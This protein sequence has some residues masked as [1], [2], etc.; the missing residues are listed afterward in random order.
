MKTPAASER[1]NGNDL[2]HLV[3]I[4]SLIE[5]VYVLS[6]VLQQDLTLPVR[7]DNTDV[8]IWELIVYLHDSTL[9][10]FSEIHNASLSKVSYSPSV[11]ST[12]SLVQSSK[13]NISDAER[14]PWHLVRII[15]LS[16]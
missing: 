2:I 9:L 16:N 12:S 11:Y 1:G 3:T 4:R 13:H 14:K 15:V 10:Y 5:H 7:I 6:G 8:Q